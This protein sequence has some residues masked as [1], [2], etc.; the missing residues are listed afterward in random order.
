M[1]GKLA[2]EKDWQY[3]LLIDDLIAH[4]HDFDPNLSWNDNT[5]H[6]SGLRVSTFLGWLTRDRRIKLGKLAY[7]HVYL[8]RDGKAYNFHHFHPSAKASFVFL[9]SS[10]NRAE[11][12]A[13]LRFLVSYAMFKDGSKESLGVATEA[14]GGGRSYIRMESGIP[15]TSLRALAA[16]V[17]RPASSRYRRFRK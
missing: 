3:S 13:Y 9:A 2:L 4:A 11:R 5:T 12:V 17:P 1:A 8:A 14:T 15:F 7:E 6:E 16:L 10:A